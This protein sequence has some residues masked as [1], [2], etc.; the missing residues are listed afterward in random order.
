MNKLRVGILILGSLAFANTVAATQD[1]K[2]AIRGAGLIDCRTYLAELEKKSPAYLMMG[3]WIDGY[4][5]GIN[6]YA[7]DTYDVTSFEST[8]L[9]AELIRNHCQKNPTDRLFPV[10]RSIVAQRW[11]SRVTRQSPLVGVKLD[12]FDVQIY[13]ETIRRIQ[14]RLTDQG[15]YKGAVTGKFDAPTIAAVAEFQKTLDGFKVTGFP[16]QAT[17]WA[18]LSK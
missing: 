16:D 11:P 7:D 12:Q 17:L 6:Q 4:I 2:F 18:L 3:G 1:G 15:L 10:M 14:K 9:F 8:E 13:Q 5:T